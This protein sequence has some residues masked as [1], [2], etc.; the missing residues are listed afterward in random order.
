MSPKKIKPS[1]LLAFK[2][3]F[4]PRLKKKAFQSIE[5]PQECLQSDEEHNLR[6]SNSLPPSSDDDSIK[7]SRRHTPD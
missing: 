2:T 3:K 4:F 1:K 6:N 5:T 7:H